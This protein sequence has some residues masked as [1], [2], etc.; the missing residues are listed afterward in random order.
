[1]WIAIEGIDGSGKSSLIKK[2]H[3]NL[4]K[5]N[6]KNII[7]REPAGT[8]FGIKIK[9]LIEDEELHPLTQ[10]CLFAADRAEHYQKVVK[11]ALEE[12]KI[13]ISDRSVFSSLAYQG[14]GYCISPDII[15]KINKLACEEKFPDMIIYLKISP[16]IA[17]D[18]IHKRKEVISNF[19]KISFLRKVDLGY[20]EISKI[21]KTITL[22]ANKKTEV[23]VEEII[24]T[25]F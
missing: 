11:P 19:E 14:Y 4:N 8:E 22:D 6:I 2:L 7:T 9:K 17:L 25:L 20:N 1:M 10:I 24:K 3:E 12:K 21:Y 13:V 16:E 5:L 23:L 18:R 15:T